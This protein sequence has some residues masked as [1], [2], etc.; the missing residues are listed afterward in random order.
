MTRTRIS[1]VAVEGVVG[2]AGHAER[3]PV[4]IVLD[5]GEQFLEGGAV[6][7]AGTLHEIGDVAPAVCAGHGLSTRTR[8]PPPGLP[9][10]HVGAA[11]A[12]ADLGA[13]GC[14]PG[15][16]PLVD[17]ERHVVGLQDLD[18]HGGHYGPEREQLC[19]RLP[20]RIPALD[21]DARPG[22][23]HRGRFI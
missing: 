9:A 4:D 6:A 2:A 13:I 16:R 7:V 21:D 10:H 19:Q 14:R 8:H 20:D 12:L 1:W 17:H 5:G 3:E 15:H 22:L 18:G 11:T 23:E